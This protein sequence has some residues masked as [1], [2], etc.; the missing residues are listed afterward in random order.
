MGAA[1]TFRFDG[2]DVRARPGDS[3]AAALEAAGMRVLGRSRAGRPRGVFCGMGACQDCLVRVDGRLSR[4]ACMTEALPGM[5]VA[6]QIDGATLPGPAE[7]EAP[8]A[9][10]IDCDVVIVGAGPAGL[11]AAVVAAGAGLRAVVLDER[12]EPGGQYHKPRSSGFRGHHAPDA[13]H[14][15][16]DAL[17]REAAASGAVLRGGETIWFAR[18]RSGGEGGGFEV[19]SVGP[20]GQL[21]STARAVILATGAT[22]RP[23][24]VPGWTLPGVTTIGAAQ[25]LARRYGAAPRGRVLIAGHGPLSLQLAVELL[26][27][28][29][30]VVAVAERAPARPLRMLR[31]G[32]ADPRLGRDGLGM[33]ARLGRAR[34]PVLWGRQVTRVDGDGRAEAAVIEDRRGRRR[35]VAAD[36]VAMGDGFVPQA[37]LARLLGVP[38]VRDGDGVAAPERDD[39]GATAV[40]GLWVAGDAGGLGGA[41]AATWQGRL[42]GAAAARHLGRAAREALEDRRDRRG[43]ARARRFQA[44]L[45]RAYAAPP[46]A[47][48]RGETVVCRC[49]HVTAA[50]IERAVAAGARDPGAVK[51]ATRCGMG[52][53]QGR[54]CTEA[55]V[56]VLE[57]AGHDVPPEALF[58]PQIPARAVPVAPLLVE[59]GEWGGHRE[60]SPSARPAAPPSG[61]LPIDWADLVVVGAG[62]TGI[63]AALHAARRGARVVCL[64]RGRINGEASGGNAGSL[65]LQLLSWDFGAKA[66]ADGSAALATLPLQS[67]AI[68]LWRALEAELDADFEMRITGGL[69]VA[70]DEAQMAFLRRKAEAEA[71]VGVETEVVGAAEIRDLVPAISERMVAGAWCAGEGKI[72]PLTATAALARAARAAGAVIEELAPT[73]AIRADGGG[74]RVETPRGA[75]AAGRVVLAAGGWSAGLARQLGVAVPVRGAPLQMIATET[76]PPLVPCLLAHA[77][78]HLTMKQTDAGTLLIGGAWTA[79][80]GPSGQP[81]VL[82]ESLEGNL[83]VAARTVPAVAGLSLVRSWAAM[84]IDIDGAPLLS[85]LPGHPG[86]VVAATANGYTLGPL[87]GREAAET[88]LSGR[89]RADLAPFTLD[90]FAEQREDA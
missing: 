44:A 7:T 54:L 33:L 68:A 15:C 34:V 85:P 41:Q 10:R 47:A 51:R 57:G 52:R 48:P 72:N 87:M 35:T 5:E 79:R 63:S 14:A 2:R 59:K 26:A 56:R 55:L 32:I 4:R 70:E 25:T 69:M 84:N 1:F 45:W 19:R 23:A 74:Y 83:W 80:T 30:D 61:A 42:A 49:E 11:S 62:V 17:R 27:L 37:E 73:T 6:P 36:T 50:A 78:R 29:A 24:M 12:G 77:D 90:R 58:A 39:D 3:V 53:C 64:D 13:Q 28:G 65:H 66:F 71:R 16:G 75:V 40:P 18:R 82:P 86:V 60:S 9:A 20:E 67:E 81:E 31:A 43:L 38:V 8:A 76:A 88:A 22:E 46:R 21:R 89:L